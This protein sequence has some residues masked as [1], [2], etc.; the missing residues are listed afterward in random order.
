MY[1]V[2]KLESTFGK[3]D[4]LSF[5]KKTEKQKP[6]LYFITNTKSSH[7]ELII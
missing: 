1:G 3:Q 7:T 5:V 2:L 6:Y 4:R